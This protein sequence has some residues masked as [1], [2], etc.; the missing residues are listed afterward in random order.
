MPLIAPPHPETWLKVTHAGLF[1]EP[2]EF[3]IDPLRAVDRAVIVIGRS[4]E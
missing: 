3:F 2:G 4:A 1:C